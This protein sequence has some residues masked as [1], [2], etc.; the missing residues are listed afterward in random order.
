MHLLVVGGSGFLGREIVRQSQAAGQAMT[1]TYH[2]SG[3]L[4]PGQDWR[5]VDIRDREAVTSLARDVRPDVVINA[6]YLQSDWATTAEG[7]HT[8]RARGNGG[9]RAAR[10]RVQRCGLLG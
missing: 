1:A 10:P 6:A 2:S 8:R 7:S 5:Q 3:A 4:T 9:G